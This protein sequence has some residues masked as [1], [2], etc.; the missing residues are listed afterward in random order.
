MSLCELSLFLLF[1]CVISA[2]TAVATIETLERLTAYR[3]GRRLLTR[4][5][6]RAMVIMSASTGFSMGALA[7]IVRFVLEWIK[8]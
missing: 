1:L 8:L 7:M 4:R 3:T 2:A 6:Y 5:E